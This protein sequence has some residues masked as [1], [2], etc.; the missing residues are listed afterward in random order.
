MKVVIYNQGELIALVS[1]LSQKSEYPININYSFGKPRSISANAQV[2][3][4]IPKIAKFYGEDNEYIRKWM[5]HHIAWPILESGECEYSAKVRYM[6]TK[7]GYEQLN[8]RQKINMLDMFGVTRFFTTKQH[9]E[10][11]DM[12]QIYWGKQGLQLR[13]L[14]D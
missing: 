1:G 11:R 14:N 2:F 7:A 8:P 4:W 10:F 6:L 5:K 12:I 9:N 3:V 13:Y